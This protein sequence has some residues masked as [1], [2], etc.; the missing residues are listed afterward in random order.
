ML[1][2]S[3]KGVPGLNIQIRHS[4]GDGKLTVSSIVLLNFLVITVTAATIE[5]D[6]VWYKE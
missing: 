4:S 2:L 3:K 6:A 5:G 1:C